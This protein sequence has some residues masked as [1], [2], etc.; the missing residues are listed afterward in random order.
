MEIMNVYFF[1]ASGI[2]ILQEEEHAEGDTRPYG[3]PQAI[4]L[5]SK[6]QARRVLLTHAPNDT[7]FD[8]AFELLEA[9]GM[10]DTSPVHAEYHQGEYVYDLVSLANNLQH[11]TVNADG[12]QIDTFDAEIDRSPSRIFVDLLPA[13]GQPPTEG[14]LGYHRARRTPPHGVLLQG[15]RVRAARLPPLAGPRR[16]RNDALLHPQHRPAGNRRTAAGGHPGRNRRRAEHGVGHI[17]PQ[18][19][20]RCR[21]RRELNALPSRVARFLFG[22]IDNHRHGC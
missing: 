14:L 12:V 9:S 1:L 17:A 15:A 8:R 5:Y 10:P 20:S 19:T 11:E 6:E 13:D 22:I 4:L 18:A 7:Q 21:R 2:L 16:A 3:M